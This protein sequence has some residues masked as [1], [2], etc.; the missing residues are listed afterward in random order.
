MA[1]STD[2]AFAWSIG[3]SRK[4][5]LLYSAIQKA[6][7]AIPDRELDAMRKRWISLEAP[8]GLDPDTV[9]LLEL[10]AFFT[11]LLLVGLTGIT[12]VLKRRLNEKIAGLRQTHEE[13][14]AS[15]QRFRAIFDH[16]PYSITI[17]NLEDGQF[18][19]VNQAFLKKS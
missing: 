18:L 9:L 7:T 16:A 5:P 13:L 19:D 4:Y 12:Y 8:S 11:G 17:N 2:Y 14:R 10:V 15:E 3:V 6:L 1:G